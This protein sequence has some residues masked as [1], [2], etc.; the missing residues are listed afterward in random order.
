MIPYKLQLLQHLKDTDKSACEDFCTQMQVVLEE[1]GLDDRL[2]FSNEATFH[3]TGKVNKHDTCIWGTEH[4]HVIQEHVRDS[5]KVNVF[6]AISKKCVYGSFFFEGTT[7]NSEAYLAML[8]FCLW[9]SE[10]TLFSN[11]MG[12]HLTGFSM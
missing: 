3:G 5:P 7:V 6:C 2:V 11:K 12:H 4:P 9:E 8:H 1:D 10:Q